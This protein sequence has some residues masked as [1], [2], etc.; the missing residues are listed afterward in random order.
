MKQVNYLYHEGK[1]V[2]I[3]PCGTCVYAIQGR[4]CAFPLCIRLNGWKGHK[5]DEQEQTGPPVCGG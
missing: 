4:V 2:Y 5:N 3:V 1:S